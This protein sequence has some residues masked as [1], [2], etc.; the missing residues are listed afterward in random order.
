MYI[1]VVDDSV[2]DDSV[3]LGVAVGVYETYD[4]GV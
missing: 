1:R 2:D 3:A 4:V